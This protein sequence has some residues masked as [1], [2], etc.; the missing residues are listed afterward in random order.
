MVGISRYSEPIC[1]RA[2]H[3]WRETELDRYLTDMACV[4]QP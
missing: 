4:S 3:Q 2:S 1:T